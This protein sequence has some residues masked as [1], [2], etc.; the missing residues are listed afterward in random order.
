LSVFLEGVAIQFYRGIGPEIQYIGPFSKMNFFIGANNSGKSII[1][2][3][4]TSKISEA[5]SRSSNG[6]TL[7][8]A[9]RGKD[10]GALFCAGAISKPEALKR[11]QARFEQRHAA[12][13]Q[14]YHF[15]TF[16]SDINKILDALS[17]NGLLWSSISANGEPVVHSN[18]APD[19]VKKSVNNWGQLASALIHNPSQYMEYLTAQ[20][21]S[22]IGQAI[23]IAL[24]KISLIPAKRQLGST[25]EEFKDLSGKG[26]IDQLASLKS[27]PFGS[28]REMDQQKEKFR[29]INDFVREITGKQHAEL[30]IP[31][32]RKYLLIKMDKK[33]L[34]LSSLGTGIHELVLIAAFCTIHDGS[35]MC[36]EE[37]EIHLHPT[38]QK[39]LIN[40]LVQNTTSQY[41]IAT[42][43]SAFIDTPDSSI[44][45]V[46]NDGSQ[47]Y[48][49]PVLTKNEQRNILNELGYQASDILQSNAVIWVE[50]P[51]DKI[52]LNHW[53][54]AYDGRLI[55]GI[56]YSIMFYGGALISHL[57]ASDDARESF[58]KLRDL[59][60]NMA[61]VMDSDRASLDAALK[62]NVKRLVEEMSEGA[63]VAWVTA[64]REIENYIEGNKLQDA[65]KAVHPSLYKKACSTGQ[66][67][68]A[69][70]FM[71]ENPKNPARYEKYTGGDKVAAANL[72]CKEEA[73]LNMLDLEERIA[74]IVA[75]IRKANSLI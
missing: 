12:N 30:E 9:Y 39:K 61:I 75:M 67:D 5:V 23:Q 70:H 37:P 43:S 13:L 32:D 44:F 20:V 4:L 34:P 26:L 10:S 71:R 8:E 51:S 31:S 74:E 38:L 1:L 72:L 54:K 52:Y 62:L 40:Y 19:V 45:H 22:E 42:H 60:R 11:I 69:F 14:S 29:Q 21:L 55:E 15:P 64:G 27:P 2:N 46:S 41:F 17:M 53:I 25:G 28:E 36:I 47:T 73:N 3:F 56:H 33:V 68:N 16:Q 65:M 6:L 63:G 7:E 59:N 18:A 35:I 49:K 57:T 58:I 24:P 50:G 66:F 48:V